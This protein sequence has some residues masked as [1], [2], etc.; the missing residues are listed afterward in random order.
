MKIFKVK[1]VSPMTDLTLRQSALRLV[2]THGFFFFIIGIF[3]CSTH[4]KNLNWAEEYRPISVEI[5]SLEKKNDKE[6]AVRLGNFLSSENKFVAWHAARII[7]SRPKSIAPIL[8]Q[9]A[10]SCNSPHFEVRKLSAEIF[11]Q[12]GKDAGSYSK[13]LLVLFDK[14]ND[15]EIRYNVLFALDRAD[16]DSEELLDALEDGLTDDSESVKLI[17]IQNA[18]RLGRKAARLRKFVERLTKDPIPRV[19]GY[20]THMLKFV[21]PN[22]PV[23][24]GCKPPTQEEKNKAIAKVGQKRIDEII[25]QSQ[26]QPIVYGH[27]GCGYTRKQI[28]DL[29]SRGINYAFMDTKANKA[30]D[31][32][33]EAMV[34][35]LTSSTSWGY[36]T[37]VYK[38]K[39]VIGYKKGLGSN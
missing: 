2:F 9:I 35:K 6:S 28:T 16:V 17:S 31:R 25:E 33:A 8:S 36:P 29:K 1:E 14:E 13:E 7:N 19:A 23:R 39:V 24:E 15:S 18:G 5:S 27:M 21:D 12:V 3:S 26:N 30:Y 4:Q 38:G 32:E 10:K 37:S 11:A 22:A 20:A 34:Y